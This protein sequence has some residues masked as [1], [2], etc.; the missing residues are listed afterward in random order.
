MKVKFYSCNSVCKLIKECDRLKC[1][2]LE[3][4]IKCIVF[5]VGIYF[6]FIL[7]NFENLIKFK[8]KLNL[9]IDNCLINGF[10]FYL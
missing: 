4:N 10:I 2:I 1:L 8:L 9:V 6:W 5:L 3:V 7:V